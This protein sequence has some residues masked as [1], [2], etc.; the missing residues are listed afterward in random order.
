MSE[1]IGHSTPC[2]VIPTRPRAAGAIVGIVETLRRR[3]RAIAVDRLWIA[4]QRI[5]STTETEFV[6]GLDLL[7]RAKI[8]ERTKTDLIQLSND[9]RR[10]MARVVNR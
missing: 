6:Y 7:L 4:I 9:A 5:C 8:A 2:G 10:G 3:T 1:A